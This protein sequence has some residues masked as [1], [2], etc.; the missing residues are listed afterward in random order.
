MVI[1]H[2]FANRSAFFSVHAV[3][4]LDLCGSHL[5]QAGNLEYVVLEMKSKREGEVK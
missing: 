5:L 2:P 1:W 4:R 3:E